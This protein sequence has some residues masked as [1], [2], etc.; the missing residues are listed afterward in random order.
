MHIPEIRNNIYKKQ[1]LFAY[2]KSAIRSTG[3]ASNFCGKEVQ[4]DKILNKNIAILN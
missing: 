4:Q 2:E 3:T 1:L